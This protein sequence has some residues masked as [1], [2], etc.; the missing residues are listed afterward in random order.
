MFCN[1]TLKVECTREKHICVWLLAS[2]KELYQAIWY[3]VCE[4]ALWGA[5]AV[6]WEKEPPGEPGRSYLQS[7]LCAVAPSQRRG[8]TLHGLFTLYLKSASIG[9]VLF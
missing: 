4:Q 5:L 1:T 6:G 3:L 2:S 9:P 8:V 7:S